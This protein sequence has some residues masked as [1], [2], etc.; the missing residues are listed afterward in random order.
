MVG[1]EAT[2]AA[3]L[4]ED[5]EA[6]DV[7]RAALAIAQSELPSID[8]D[9]YVRQL[10]LMAERIAARV[11][12]RATAQEKVLAIN[13]HLFQDLGFRGNLEDYY[14][15]Q[16]SFLN[17]V[18]DRRLGIPITLSLVY[19]E[20]GR[21]LGLP[22]VGVGLPGHFVVKVAD[23]DGEILIDPFYQGVVLDRAE[24][25]RRLDAIYGGK[26]TLTEPFLAAVG[27]RDVLAR[28]L[29][30]L[31]RIYLRN[32]DQ[33]RAIDVL[34]KLL[35]LQPYAF[36]DRRDRGMLLYKAG[37]YAAALDDLR[38]YLQFLPNASDAASVQRAIAACERL[39]TNA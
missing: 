17:R 18:L 2:F 6:L 23:A 11:G 37:A 20:V 4:R 30:N 27:K 14:D 5:D 38:A 33:R 24:C 32:N 26:V 13:Q 1:G 25:Q 16:N 8:S 10:D 39:R 34:D 22:I 29:Y 36:E 15:P 3:M 28:M 31:K 19:I 35:V 9:A 7:A 21:R 12:P